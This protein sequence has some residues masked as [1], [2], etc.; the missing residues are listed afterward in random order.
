MIY[1]ADSASSSVAAALDNITSAATGK[2]IPQILELVSATLESTDDDGDQ[3]MLNSQAFEDFEDEE[4]EDADGNESDDNFDEYFPGD[5]DMNPRP[6]LANAFSVASGGDHTGMTAASRQRIRQ[7]LLIA[8]HEGFKV[9]HQGGLMD[10]LACYLSLSI[11]ISKLGISEEAMQAWQLD[12]AE[13]LVM[14][15]HYPRGYKTMDDIRSYDGVTA[16]LSF[17]IRVGV[18]TTYKPTMQEAITAFTILSK[19]EEKR[20]G[21]SQQTESQHTSQMPMG[22]RDSFISRPLNELLKDRFHLILQYRYGGMPWHGAESFYNDQVQ[23]ASAGNQ[24]ASHDKYYDDESLSNTWPKIVTDD[25]ITSLVGQNHSLPLVAMQFVL[26]HFVRCTE[27]CLICFNKMPDDLQAIKPYVCDN[28]LCLYQ[29]MS[30]GFGPSIEHEILS[31][32]K[33]VDLLV[34][35]C[36][37]SAR[38]GR[39]RDFPTGLGLSVPPIESYEYDYSTNLQQNSHMTYKS[40]AIKDSILVSPVKAT[41]MKYNPH[42]TEIL[43]E[44]ARQTCPLATGQWIIMRTDTDP[45]TALHCR[46]VD[47]SYYPSVRVSQPVSPAKADAQTDPYPQILYKQQQTSLLSSSHEKDLSPH[48]NELPKNEFRSASFYVYDQN[49]D[50]LSEEQKRRLIVALLDVLPSVQEMRKYISRKSQSPLSTWVDRLSPAMLGVLR[51]II[52]SNRACILQV[53]S[54]E[55]ATQIRRVEDRLYGMAGF[56]QFRFAMGAPD[57]ERRFIQAVRVT[58]QRLGLKYPT[59]FAWHGSPLQNWHSIIREGLHFNETMNGRAYGDGV[60]HS[61]H[62]GTSLGYSNFGNAAAYWPSSELK[63]QQALALN[64]IVNAPQEY[65]SQSPHYVVAQLDWIQTR[66]LFVKTRSN[67][68]PDPKNNEM[69]PLECLEQDPSRTPSG[70]GGDLVIPVHAIAAARRNKPKNAL[71]GHSFDM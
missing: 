23:N 39:L 50:D 55:D 42:T 62:V 9:G 67:S 48:K 65:V 17:G 53:D 51:W 71:V 58:T 14:I 69:K 52:A 47:V 66:Y 38:L 59:L 4:P 63:I 43:F 16:R 33:V 3:Q 34:S 61:P 30:L 35:F 21:E 44:N 56:A 26:R 18:S 8:K 31:Q 11:R 19:E 29:Y 37:T 27:F 64:E 5:E 25:H 22:F 46:V 49:F 41:S 1:A 20:R 36:Y 32:P 10:G 13:Y 68:V 40:S 24:D 70:I 6:F 12:P 28:P 60:Y 57:K 2:T 45:D 7:D 54:E 15:L